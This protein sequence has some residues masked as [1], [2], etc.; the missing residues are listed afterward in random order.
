MRAQSHPIENQRDFRAFR[1]RLG[2]RSEEAARELIQRFEPMV[3]EVIR[4]RLDRR[5]RRRFDSE[6][7]SQEVWASFFS[8]PVNRLMAFEN[9]RHLLAF[10]ARVAR[11]KALQKYYQ[12]IQCQKF[13]LRREVLLSDLDPDLTPQ[14]EQSSPEQLAMSNEVWR[15]LVGNLPQRHQQILS[16]LRDSYTHGEIADSLG[17]SK[18][19]VQRT[20]Q[21]F[22]LMAKSAAGDRMGLLSSC[23]SAPRLPQGEHCD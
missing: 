9:P 10:L 16:M 2:E 11:N 7:L 8:L 22:A 12:Q 19:T 17:I 1:K 5:L 6:D 4:R 20:V 14:M 15:Q 21:G 13:D 18:K 3:M 23:S